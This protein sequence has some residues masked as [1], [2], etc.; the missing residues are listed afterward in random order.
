[1]EE[2]GIKVTR[3]QG[4]VGE[5][6]QGW[7]ERRATYQRWNEITLKRGGNAALPW[8][9]AGIDENQA[10]YPDYDRFV[11]YKD[12]ETGKLIGEYAKAFENAPACRVQKANGAPASPFVSVV[13]PTQR[14][15]L[16]WLTAKAL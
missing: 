16:G 10:R 15:A 7:E 8:M 2:Y 11:F 1:L 3:A 5:V 4:N 14:V 9:L 6:T 12:D 13:H